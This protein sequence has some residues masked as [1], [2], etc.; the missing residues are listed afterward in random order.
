MSTIEFYLQLKIILALTIG[1]AAGVI[2]ILRRR[3]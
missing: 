3:K 1:V 2:W